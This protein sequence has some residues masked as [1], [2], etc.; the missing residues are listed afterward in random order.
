MCKQKI[1]IE[2]NSVSNNWNN[3]TVE[4]KKYECAKELLLTHLKMKIPTNYVS[5]QMTDVKFWC[6]IAILET[7]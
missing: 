4:I 5:K 3:L 7:I 6:Y 1:N 2:L